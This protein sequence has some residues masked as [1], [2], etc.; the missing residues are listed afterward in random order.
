MTEFTRVEGGVDKGDV[1]VFA[2]STCVWCR[3]TKQ[4]LDGFGVRYSYVFVDLLGG[5][6]QDDAMDEM[7]RWN[8]SC[9]FPTIVINDTE[10]IR[11][12]DEGRIRELLG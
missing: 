2:L 6:E 3:R 9:S 10:V 7:R 1:K 11:G 8:P 5:R 4:M 12:F